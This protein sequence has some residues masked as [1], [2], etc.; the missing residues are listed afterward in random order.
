MINDI[1]FYPVENIKLVVTKTDIKYWQVHLINNNSNTLKNTLVT[2]KGYGESKGNK[3]KTSVLRHYFEKVPANGSVIIESITDELFHLF[4]EYW[5]S[6]YIG[7]QIYD[8][9]F[10]FVP[11]SIKE[12]HLVYIEELD[13]T[14]VL[15]S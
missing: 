9:K 1:A 7:N 4:N 10:L 3:Q 13:L 11:E 14:G 6:Y 8:K 12:E 5:I 15:H 2:S